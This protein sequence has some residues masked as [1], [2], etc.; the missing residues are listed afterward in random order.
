MT[1]APIKLEGRALYW[2]LAIVYA[3]GA[4]RYERTR[5]FTAPG[6]SL[7][8]QTVGRL[9][10]QLSQVLAKLHDMEVMIEAGEAAPAQ[11]RR[12][13]TTL[14]EDVRTLLDAI[15]SRVRTLRERATASAS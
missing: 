11:P 14:R 3:M 7:G 9:T 13:I 6:H 10:S 12:R 15:G 5:D 8:V 2:A 4:A 1:A